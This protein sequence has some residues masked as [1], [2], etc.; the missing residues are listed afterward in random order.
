MSDPQE[1]RAG[2]PAT[3]AATLAP[4]GQFRRVFDEVATGIAV[5]DTDG[6][7]LRVNPAYCRTVGYSADELAHMDFVSLTHPDDRAANLEWVEELLTGRRDSFVIEKRY[8]HRS[9]E[10]VW[11]RATVSLLRD[12]EGRPAQLVATTEDIASQKATERRL[13][14]S[15]SLLRIAGAVGRVGGWA[16][17]AGQTNHYWSE[18]V[19]DILGYPEIPPLDEA[20]RIYAPGDREEVAAAVEA[21][22]TDGTPFDLELRARRG[23]G[24]PLWARVVG[25]PL[26]A[27]DG[28]IVRIQGALMDVTER[29]RAELETERLADRLTTTLESITDSFYTLDTHWRFTYLNRR[30]QEVLQR[31]AA[32]VVG[33]SI[34]EVFPAVVGSDLEEAYR[35]AMREERTVVLDEYHYPP[36]DT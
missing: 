21:C 24:Q 29:R 17:D 36:L 26:Y 7:F 8:V 27:P 31:D 10:P 15:Q 16:I 13:E 33:R 1:P 3:D 4:D 18:E 28:S 35:R 12:D 30:A 6:R 20:F 14:E 5:A 22:L 25:E 34:W 9:G 23:D 2:V 11:V 32:D 19:H